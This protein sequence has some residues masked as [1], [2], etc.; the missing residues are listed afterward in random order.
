MRHGKNRRDSTKPRSDLFATRIVSLSADTGGAN[1]RPKRWTP[2]QLAAIN[3]AMDRKGERK[4]NVTIPAG[5]TYLAQFV[6][7]DL[8]F[9]SFT[10]TRFAADERTINYAERPALDLSSLYGPGPDAAPH[11]YQV[12]RG[13][14]DRWRLKLGAARLRPENRAIMNLE[15]LI[16]GMKFAPGQ[17]DV[18]AGSEPGQ[19]LPRCPVDF[20]KRSDAA[21][22]DGTAVI[23]DP[24]NDENLIISQ[25]TVLLSRT[26]N[27]VCEKLLARNYGK[28]DVFAAA[29][30]MMEHSYRRIVVKD[31]LARLL[32]HEEYAELFP[33]GTICV[34][35]ESRLRLSAA[36]SM[37]RGGDLPEVF[38][39]AA[40]RIG[41]A[42]IQDK[43]V[44]RKMSPNIR[45]EAEAELQRG[46]IRELIELMEPS[47]AGE[48]PPIKSKWIVDWDRFFFDETDLMS[49]APPRL[50]ATGAEVNFSHAIMLSYPRGLTDKTFIPLRTDDGGGGLAYRDIARSQAL[51]TAQDFV[52]DEGLCRRT[53]LAAENY[54]LER[55]KDLELPPGASRDLR[56]DL[57]ARSPLLLYL[58]AEA[59]MQKRSPQM[60]GAHLGRLGSRIVGEVLLAALCRS[61]GRDEAYEWNDHIGRATPCSMPELLAF[62][63]DSPA[64]SS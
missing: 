64:A 15:V 41:H 39:R 53:Y 62:T 30:G 46:L 42:M 10:D 43:Y 48:G 54:L 26:H 63:R 61:G 29:R 45:N 13:T 57:A 1:A 25:L 58:L 52:A 35:P 50:R 23:A 51:P 3:S 28:S 60:F 2:A 7:H 9:H 36:Q 19:D 44:I 18:Y 14:A 59:E 11:L 40:F 16:N 17:F 55:I 37:L 6:A 8:A 32:H 33:A 21:N 4:D 49:G 5:Y 12:E 47:S 31:L 27:L 20:L 38:W 34:E 22:F 24:R 56:A